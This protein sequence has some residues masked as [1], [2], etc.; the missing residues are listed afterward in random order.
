[1]YIDLCVGMRVSVCVL[2]IK[3]FLFFSRLGASKQAFLF[4][5]PPQVTTSK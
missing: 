1:M 2:P 5:L 4:C 3:A